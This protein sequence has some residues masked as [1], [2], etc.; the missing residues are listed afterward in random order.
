VSAHS[1]TTGPSAAA[2]N[3]HGLPHGVAGAELFGLVDDL[4]GIRRP[5]PPGRGRLG[6]PIRRRFSPARAA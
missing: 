4:N 3:Y 6:V 5:W 1:T 2:M